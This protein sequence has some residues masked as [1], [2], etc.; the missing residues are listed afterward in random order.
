[1]GA[2]ETNVDDTEPIVNCRY[3]AI[4]VSLDVEDDTIGTH[5]AGMS[6]RCFDIGRLLPIGTFYSGKPSLQ[7]LLGIW[8]LLPEFT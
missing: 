1:M 4:M 3:Q 7:W 2:D 8:M 6:K 5:K